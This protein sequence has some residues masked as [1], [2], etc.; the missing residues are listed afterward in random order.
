MDSLKQNKWMAWTNKTVL[1]VGGYLDTP[2]GYYASE[3]ENSYAKLGYNVWLLDTFRLT[4]GQ[5]GILNMVRNYN[6]KTKRGEWSQQS[7]KAAV[8]SFEQRIRIQIG[9]FRIWC[10]SNNFEIHS[11]IRSVCR[12]LTSCFENASPKDILPIPTVQINEKRKNYRRGKTA[13][14]T[15]TPYKKELQALKLSKN[16]RAKRSKSSKEVPA[17]NSKSSKNVTAKNSKVERKT[18]PST[19]R[20]EDSVCFYCNDLHHTYLKSTENWVKCQLCGRWA[21]TACAGVDDED[22]EEVLIYMF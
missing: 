14:I 10:S 7:M 18:R 2:G 8:D 20:Q 21:H 17:K 16:V 15:S 5:N 19:S 3:I 6:K 13:V 12:D 9:S 1:Y 4:L 11:P 22:L